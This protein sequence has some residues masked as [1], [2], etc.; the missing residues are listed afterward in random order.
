MTEQTPETIRY[1]AD[2]V[3]I[4]TDRHVLLIERDRAPHKDA[5]ALPG[6][7]VDPG[8]TSRAAAVR[9]AE[10]AGVYVSE[11]EVKQLGVWERLNRSP[12]RCVTVGYCLEVIPATSIEAGDDAIRAEWW[13]LDALPPLALTHYAIIRA[14]A[15][16]IDPT[17]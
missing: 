13:S 15:K 12:G 14:A 10:E 5:W 2:V 11:E 3:V 9:L 6:G 4:T 16:A 7:H 17:A 1:T 8:E